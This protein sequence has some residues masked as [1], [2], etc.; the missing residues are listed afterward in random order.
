MTNLKI[1]NNSFNWGSLVVGLFSIIIAVI[2]FRQPKATLGSLAFV[3]AI[4]AIVKG[5]W[6]IF[7]NIYTKRKY[8]YHSVWDYIV[9][10]VNIVAGFYLLF[11]LQI[12]IV[13]IPMIFAFW[14]LS[15]SII[16]LLSAFFVR[17]YSK[18]FFV[19]SIIINVINI[20]LAVLLI[21]NPI[22]SI[23]TVVILIGIHFFLNGVLFIVSAF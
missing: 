2:A 3:F 21:S 22:A 11:N 7:I 23:L 8:D 6:L 16:G 9:S 1:K 14:F 19:L 15:E 17:R 18:G 5:I 20:I 10:C 4:L 12:G 13:I